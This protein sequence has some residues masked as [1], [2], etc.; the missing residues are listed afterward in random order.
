[1]KILFYPKLAWT[2]LKNNR[3]TSVPYILTC[4]GMVMIFYIVSFLSKSSDVQA[5]T[6]G[7]DI[8]AILSLGVGVIGIFSVI[9]LF[10]TNSFLIRRRKKEFGLYNILG[11]GK[12]NIAIIV[13]WE[14]IITSI[15]SIVMGLT[16]GILFSK[17]AELC[18]LKLW[19]GSVSFSF[20]INISVIIYSVLLFA[21]IFT[22]IFLNSIRQIHVSKPVDLINNESQGEKPPKGNWIIAIIGVLM[23]GG[24]YYISFTVDNPLSALTLFFIAV[25]MV[26]VATYMLFISGSVTMCRFLQK[27]KRYY[28]NAKHFVSTS[29]MAYRMKRNGAGL[30]SICILSTMVLVM[31]SSTACLYFGAE[32]SINQIYPKDIIIDVASSSDEFLNESKNT[33]DSVAT[34]ISAEHGTNM[35]SHLKYDYLSFVGFMERDVMVLDDMN[36]GMSD[37]SNTW[38]VF[39]IPIEDYN[40]ITNSSESLEPGEIIIQLE[41]QNR[42]LE[43]LTID[44]CETFNVKKSVDNFIQNGNASRTIYPTIYIFSG[45]IDLI[46]EKVSAKLDSIGDTN[47]L[48]HFYYGFDLSCDDEEQIAVQKEISSDISSIFSEQL[49]DLDEGISMSLT[50]DSKAEGRNNFYSLYGGL[51]VLGII[52][53]GVFICAAVLIIYYKQISEGYEDVVKFDIMQ[54]VGMTKKEIRKSINSQVLTVFFL[55]ILAAGIHMVFAFP[56]IYR[57]L[58]LLGITDMNFLLLVSVI[59]FLIFT[60]LYIVVYKL[61]SKAYYSVVSATN[62]AEKRW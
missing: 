21:V 57:L 62:G 8:Q 15:I 58:Q 25:I 1:M 41:K 3:K 60:I 55:P 39:V 33:V 26:I 40:T 36:I 50:V 42:E 14:T 19:D 17:L 6:G 35:T 46:Q 48:K 31:L 44:G 23:L 43:T 4:I 5:M 16:C 37:V 30:A 24:A 27:N 22:L 32:N 29:S 53:G 34:R 38:E 9:F 45:N 52:L 13:L 20:D 56:C 11:M 7:D 51:F 59:S 2:G 10:Y 12:K 54:K 18:I 47:F 28:Y 61:T 49:H